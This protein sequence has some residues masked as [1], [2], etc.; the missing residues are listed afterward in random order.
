MMSYTLLLGGGLFCLA[1]PAIIV[2]V[3]LITLRGSN[4]STLSIL[5]LVLGI[6]GLIFVLP[7]VGPVGA[8]ISGN[9]ALRQIRE[10]PELTPSNNEGMARAGIILGWIGIAIAALG[11]L[12]LLMFLPVR[13][14]TT[15]FLP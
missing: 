2:V 6:L 8:V 7:V 4:Q 13:T 3:L 14:V 10:H 1:I 9:M 15:G 11:L 5:S 12:G